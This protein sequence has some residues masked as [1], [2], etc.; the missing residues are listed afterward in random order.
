[1]SG[2]SNKQII[3]KK[4]LLYT[5]TQIDKTGLCW[6]CVQIWKRYL[7]SL[8]VEWINSYYNHS[9]S[10]FDPWNSNY[11]SDRSPK[12]NSSCIWFDH[13]IVLNHSNLT[14]FGTGDGV[15]SYISHHLFIYLFVKTK[16]KINQT[17]KQTKKKMICKREGLRNS[18]LFTI[19]MLIDIKAIGWQ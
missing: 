15:E 4:K 8:S 17:N 5:K 3:I 12:I 1:M 16:Q 18:N 14:I 19:T 13:F 6:Q 2:L 10:T 7:H 9:H 11:R